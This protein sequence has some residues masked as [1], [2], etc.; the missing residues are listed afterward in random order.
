MNS[1]L[2]HS[3]L[4]DDYVKDKGISCKINVKLTNREGKRQLVFR[5]NAQD[6]VANPAN[7]VAIT[8]WK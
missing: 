4:Y 7:I 3:R 1:F 2:I 5:S 6:V 8:T